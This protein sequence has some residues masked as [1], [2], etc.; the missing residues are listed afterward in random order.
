[1]DVNIESE[2]GLRAEL[3]HLRR[4]NADL[5]ALA[6]TTYGLVWERDPLGSEQDLSK[7]FLPDLILEEGGKPVSMLE[8]NPGNLII[9]GNNVNALKLL[10][11]TH[12]GMFDCIFLDPPY[13]TGNQTWYYNDNFVNPKHRFKDSGWLRGSSRAWNS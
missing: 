3:A 6:S 11:T 2:E 10:L 12:A 5:Q 4:Q 7:V 8:D 13:G 1:M 9:E